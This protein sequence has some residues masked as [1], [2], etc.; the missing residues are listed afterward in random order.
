MNIY[1][2][3]ASGTGK[4]TLANALASKLDMQVSPSVARQSPY[5]MGSAENQSYVGSKVWH[6]IKT[7]DNSIVTRTPLDV[8]AF[9]SLWGHDTYMDR[10]RSADFCS[11]G[12]IILFCPLYWQ[13]EDDG[14]RPTDM[15]ELKRVNNLI[16]DFLECTGAE[17]YTV[18]NEPVDYRVQ[19]VIQYLETVS[20]KIEKEKH[21]A[22]VPIQNRI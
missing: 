15:A 4:S 1:L 21:D 14:F 10:Y 17:Y 22:P 5:E 13:P 20:Y 11:Q 8:L 12:N 16:R 6:Q 2:T 7:S 9:S 3:G 18:L 19:S